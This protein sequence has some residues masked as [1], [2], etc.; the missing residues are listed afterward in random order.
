M[1][2]GRCLALHAPWRCS[3]FW[4]DCLQ[5][6]CAPSEAQESVGAFCRAAAQALD[7]KALLGE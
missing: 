6:E 3:V 1:L 2:S 5:D 7:S 4:H